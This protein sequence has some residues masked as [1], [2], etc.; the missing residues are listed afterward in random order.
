MDGK[1]VTSSRRVVVNVL[2]TDQ[3]VN[4]DTVAGATGV[5]LVYNGLAVNGR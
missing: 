5:I 1:P 4:T 2:L 3:I